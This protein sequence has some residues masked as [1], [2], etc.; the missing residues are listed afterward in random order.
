MLGSILFAAIGVLGAGYSVVV[1]AVALNHGP[2]CL[3]YTNG[4]SE[5]TT[6]FTDG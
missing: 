6:P 5:W 1:S 3:V 2:K 4:T